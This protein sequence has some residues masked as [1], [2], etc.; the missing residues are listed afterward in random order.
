MQWK[1]KN[2]TRLIATHDSDMNSYYTFVCFCFCSEISTG[3]KSVEV[4]AGQNDQ[5]FGYVVFFWSRCTNIRFT[6]KNGV[7]FSA[8]TFCFCC[9]GCQIV[10]AVRHAFHVFNVCNIC[11]AAMLG[12]KHDSHFDSLLWG[13]SFLAKP[14]MLTRWQCWHHVDNVD[15]IG[16]RSSRDK[17]PNSKSFSW[18]SRPRGPVL[19]VCH[20]ETPNLASRLM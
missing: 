1:N 5:T 19:K 20:G 8:L 7:C 11:F 16:W 13:N 9:F 17:L 10:C 14:E 2:K 15:V 18:A 4:Q 6:S 12:L 3:L